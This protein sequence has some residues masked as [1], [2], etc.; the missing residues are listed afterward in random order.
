MRT[1]WRMLDERTSEFS[2]GIME[3]ADAV[4]DR[5]GANVVSARNVLVAVGV[6]AVVALVLAVVAIRK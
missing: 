6:L 4:A 5:F 3:R 2:D 1:P